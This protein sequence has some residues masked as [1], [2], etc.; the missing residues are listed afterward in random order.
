VTARPPDG[1]IEIDKIPIPPYGGYIGRD[2]RIV[3]PERELEAGS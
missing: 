2:G 1:E 3:P